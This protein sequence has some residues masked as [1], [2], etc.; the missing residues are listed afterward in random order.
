MISS[1]LIEEKK[2]YLMN[3]TRKIYNDIKYLF[4]DLRIERKQKK[5]NYTVLVCNDDR[6]R[7]IFLKRINYLY[8]IY[9]ER[10]IVLFGTGCIVK[11][12]LLNSRIIMITKG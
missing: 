4:P 5:Y 1:E 6:S 10:K 3:F 7:K 12:V 9:N 11:K 2:F 8:Y